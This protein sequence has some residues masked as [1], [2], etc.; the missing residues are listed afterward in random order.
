LVGITKLRM[1]RQDSR[2]AVDVLFVQG[3]GAM[4]APEG[5]GVLADFLRRDLGAGY[6]VVAPEMPGADTDPR[7]EPWRDEVDRQLGALG[8]GI[9]LVG[10]SLGGS[11]LLK[12]LAEKQSPVP[13]AGIFL[14]SVPWWGPEG[15]DYD[16]FAMPDEFAHTLPAVPTFLYNSRYDTTVPYEHQALYL[17]RMPGVIAR[18]IEGS[19]HSFVNG[20]PELVTDIRDVVPAEST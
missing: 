17:E 20:L 16:E 11:V 19:E 9:A 10:H 8:G 3:A 6:N 18:T 7:Y 1:G 5:S 14:V 13:V 2:V 12:D 15:W 4:N